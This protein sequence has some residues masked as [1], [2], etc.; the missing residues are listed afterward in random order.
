[1]DFTYIT[2]YFIKDIQ[3]KYTL[4]LIITFYCAICNCKDSH[5]SWPAH[6][7]FVINHLNS[8]VFN[9]S[10]AVFKHAAVSENLVNNISALLPEEHTWLIV[11]DF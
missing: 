4:S 7:F 8:A 2:Q 6:E 11:V 10:D 1:M 5:W 9:F 3:Q